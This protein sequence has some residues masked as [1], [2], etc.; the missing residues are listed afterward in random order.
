MLQLLLQA[1]GKLL[2]SPAFCGMTAFK[3]AAEQQSRQRRN[4]TANGKHC[5]KRRPQHRKCDKCC[6]QLDYLPE[7]F[8]QQR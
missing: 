2:G 7:N 5:R 1:G 4:R 8:R 6:A 3:N